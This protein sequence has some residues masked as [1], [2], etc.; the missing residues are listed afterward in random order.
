VVRVVVAGGSLGGLTA[1]LWLRDAGCDV[2][3]CERSRTPLRGQGAGIVLNPATVRWLVERA[4]S[5]LAGI[6]LPTPRVRYLGADGGVTAELPHTY[7]VTSYDTLYRNLLTAFGRERYHL[8]EEIASVP[9]GCDLLV[10]ADGIRST[11]RARLVPGAERRYAGYYAWR[12]TVSPATLS[13]STAAVLDD[14]I[15]YCVLPHGHFLAYP[16]PTT[17]AP[18]LNWLWYRNVAAGAELAALLT[19]RTG[20]RREVSVPPGAVADG[21][22][23]GLRAGASALPPPAAEAIL[24][25]AEP[26]LQPVFDIEVPRMAFGGECLIGDAAFVARPHAAAGS[27]KAAEDGY[28][29]GVAMRACGG[30]VAAALARWEPPQLALG[31]AVLAR[32]RAAGER[33]QFSGT[34]R[35]GDPLPYGLHA[36][37]DSMMP[38]T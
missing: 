29:L 24:A 13:R 22:L 3:V 4:G 6:G 35:A 12:G 1:A 17:A 34:W 14:A 27:A 19:D 10:W 5:G 15:T 20:V 30:D 33:S 26:F 38:V 28:R 25:T 21:P 16:I 11:G 36:V 8:G 37:G 32:T 18:V 7:R 31:R 9:D 23:A 2:D